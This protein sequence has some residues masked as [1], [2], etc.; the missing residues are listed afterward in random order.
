MKSP[1]LIGAVVAGGLAVAP[2]F[3]GQAAEE[4]I[5]QLVSAFDGTPSA[6]MTVKN[7]Q[8]NWFDSHAELALSVD[9]EDQGGVL[10]FDYVLDLNHGP[11]LL[12]GESTLGWVSWQGAI[13]AGERIASVLSW[14]TSR[15]FYQQNG[16]VGLGGGLDFDESVVAFTSKL[17]PNE[18]VFS[19]YDGQ[20]RQQDGSIVYSGGA[21]S[22]VIKSESGPMAIR[23]LKTEAV[24]DADL[25]KI[26][27]SDLYNSEITVLID[28][29]TAGNDLAMKQL[30]INAQTA[31]HEDGELVDMSGGY[32]IASIQ[33]QEHSVTDLG[34]GFEM[35]NISAEFNTI[36]TDKLQQAIDNGEDI[37]EATNRILIETLPTLLASKPVMEIKDVRFTLPQ[38]RFNANMMLAVDAVDQL[39]PEQMADPAFWLDKLSITADA[40]VKK[41]LAQ[42]LATRMLEYQMLQDPEVEVSPE[43]VAQF[44]E[45]QSSTVLSMLQGQGLISDGGEDFVVDF[46][47]QKGQAVLNGNAIPLDAMLQQ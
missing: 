4:K 2:Y 23:G 36:Y 28:E 14:D 41:E 35:R 39:A 19:G 15:S 16:V 43:E 30:V 25:Y 7:Y 17:D 34:I 3:V 27:N 21:D 12:S 44:A 38:G 31:M 24:I 33:V 9:L 26:I 45:M 42:M 46:S 6:K 5:H 10:T 29:I 8:R 18:I 22:L 1:V 13:E 20:G 11:I 37:S 47:L 40:K 32:A